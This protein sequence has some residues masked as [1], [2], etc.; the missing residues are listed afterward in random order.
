MTSFRRRITGNGDGGGSLTIRIRTLAIDGHGV[1]FLLLLLFFFLLLADHR[2]SR[3][4]AVD[5]AVPVTTAAIALGVELEQEA[6]E[7]LLNSLNF[8]NV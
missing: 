3:R 4:R 5:Q 2:D 8:T 1:D 6:T 7:I